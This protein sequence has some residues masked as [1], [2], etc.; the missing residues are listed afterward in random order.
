MRSRRSKHDAVVAADDDEGYSLSDAAGSVDFVVVVDC[1][2]KVVVVVAEAAAGAAEVAYSKSCYFVLGYL[3]SLKLVVAVGLHKVATVA[4]AGA[5]Q[6]P[7]RRSVAAMYADRPL[8]RRLWKRSQT[9][10][11]YGRQHRRLAD[12]EAGEEELVAVLVVMVVGVAV[13]VVVV[14]A[15]DIAVAFVAYAGVAEVGQ[16]QIL[17]CLAPY[18]GDDYYGDVAVVVP[19]VADDDDHDDDPG[20]VVALKYIARSR[21]NN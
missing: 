17:R 4:A 13:V 7:G 8:A 6:R 16:V 9:P 10:D 21:C 18:E 2:C 12:M 1:A 15:G 20:R 14:V 3:V 5:G 11:V 19:V